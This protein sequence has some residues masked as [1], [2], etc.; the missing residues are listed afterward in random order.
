MPKY[1]VNGESVELELDPEYVAVKFKAARRSTMASAVSDAGDLG[2]YRNRI[3]VPEFGL[4]LLPT[5]P[6]TMAAA[7]SENAIRSMRSSAAVSQAGMVFRRG[8]TRSCIL[9]K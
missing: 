2:D 3:E 6:T 4:T 8:K 9:W 7:R 1:L 5:A